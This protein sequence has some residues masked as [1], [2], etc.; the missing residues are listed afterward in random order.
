MKIINIRLAGIN[1]KQLFLF[2]SV[3]LTQEDKFMS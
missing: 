1:V 2:T 3:I